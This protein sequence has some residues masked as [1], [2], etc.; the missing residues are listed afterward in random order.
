MKALD[1][2]LHFITLCVKDIVR[3][4]AF[5]EAL[6]WERSRISRDGVI[7]FP[8]QGIILALHSREALAAEAT[9]DAYGSGFSGVALSYHAKSKAEVDKIFQC[10]TRLGASI[11]KHPQGGYATSYKGYFKDPDEHLFEV[12]FN[13]FYRFDKDNNV[14]LP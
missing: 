13:P 10:V 6:G 8:L 7:F 11:V 3:S 5:Y 9:I 4:I 12:T 2:K 1:Q 14:I